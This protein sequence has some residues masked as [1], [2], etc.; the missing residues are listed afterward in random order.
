[1]HRG[2][3]SGGQETSPERAINLPEKA[4]LSIAMASF[5]VCGVA[6]SC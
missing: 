6:P 3:K 4:S 5:A 2:V 1:M